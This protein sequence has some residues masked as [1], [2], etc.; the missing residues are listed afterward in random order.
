MNHHKAEWDDC[1][2]TNKYSISQR[3]KKYPFSKAVKIIAVSYLLS[4]H[5]DTDNSGLVIKNGVLNPKTIKESVRLSAVQ[6][7]KLT[8]LIY[9]TDY[10]RRQFNIE[11]HASCFDPRNSILFIGKDGKI[12][13]TMDICFEC[14]NTYSTSGRLTVGTDCTQKYDL[15]KKFFISLGIKYGTIGKYH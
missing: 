10:R 14:L 3:L 13:D 9:N 11:N 2:F 4:D 6:I 1:I 7:E 12:F 15:M 5:E 8:N